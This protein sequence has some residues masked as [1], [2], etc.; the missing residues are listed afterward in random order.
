MTAS[1]QSTTPTALSG[2]SRVPT[3]VIGSGGL[4]GQAVVRRLHA[5]R[6]PLLTTLIPW[7]TTDDATAALDGGMAQLRHV[8]GDGPWRIAWCAG[9]GVTGTPP[10]VLDQE[11][12]TFE[13]FLDNNADV[14][15][16]SSLFLASSAGAV[17]AG[18]HPA[19]FTELHQ[20]R[21][22]S[23]YGDAKLATESTAIDWAART[24]ARV[25]IGRISNLYGPGQN[26]A[27]PQGLI[28][29]ICRAQL[30]AQ[31]ISVYVSLDTVRDYL[32]VDDAAGLIL[33]GLDRI[34]TAPAGVAVV[35]ILASQQGVTVG[36]LL[37]ECRRLVKRSPRVVLG[38]SPYARLQVRD[39]RMRSVVWPELDRRS[40]TP[41]P[42]GIHAT[43][44]D[45]LLRVQ[46]GQRSD[47][48]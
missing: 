26:L 9:A 48:P 14:A 38:A 46:R 47:A 24:G 32:Y 36:A 4:L 44:T 23:A 29:H 37:A 12:A 2:A 40:L 21:S 42:A 33:D 15:D 13:R 25:V 31:P 19:P 27:K 7:S 18:A 3:W 20:P 34:A 22:I 5:T 10:K 8:A 39:L 35:K 41:L 45:L 11:V 28:S 30:A 43:L 1:Q 17:Y 16:G 6:T